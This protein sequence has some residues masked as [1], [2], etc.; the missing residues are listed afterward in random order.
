MVTCL[1]VCLCH[2]QGQ[3]GGGDNPLAPES[4]RT[5]VYMT[6]H[7][8]WLMG[9]LCCL[10]NLSFLWLLGL[11]SCRNQYVYLYLCTHMIEAFPCLYI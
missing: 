8:A 11:A 7:P 2:P 4:V 5:Y 3:A 9:A 6:T 1:G 10:V